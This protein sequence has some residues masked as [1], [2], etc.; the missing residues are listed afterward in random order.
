MTR[1]RLTAPAT[2]NP[3]GGFTLVEALVAIV[4]LSVGL[5]AVAN[6]M[7]V[8]GTSNSVANASTAS[9]TIASR[10]LERLTAIPYDE[11]VAGGDLDN[12]DPGYFNEETVP[13][14]GLV[15][16]RWTILSP[17]NQTR[18]ITV[19]AEVLG[20]L[21]G[22]RSRAEYTIFRACTSVPLGCPPPP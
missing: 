16:T 22:R 13:G 9:A 3:E 5:M 6:L 12:N 17:E 11:L 1:I 20:P 2:A 4:V 14:V 21:L 15:R 19:R 10:E 7:V 8:A 18:F